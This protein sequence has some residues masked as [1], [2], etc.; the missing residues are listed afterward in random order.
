MR[1]GLGG[2]ICRARNPTPG[3]K[4]SAPPVPPAPC[5][6]SRAPFPSCGNPPQGRAETA[7]LAS[8]SHSIPGVPSVFK[9]EPGLRV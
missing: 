6:D 5:A 8:S 4:D 7:A 2:Q 3:T 1:K 9:A